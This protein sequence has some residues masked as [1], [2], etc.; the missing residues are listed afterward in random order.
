MRREVFG[1]VVSV[2]RFADADQAIA[3]ANDSDYGLASSV[4]T[5]DVS[6]AMRVA[7]ALHY[8]CTW[9]NT[10]FMLADEMPHAARRHEAVGLRQGY[11]NLRARRLHRRAPRHGRALRRR[12]C[13]GIDP[14]VTG[15]V[16]QGIRVMPYR[17]APHHDVPPCPAPEPDAIEVSMMTGPAP[18]PAPAEPRPNGW[19]AVNIYLLTGAAFVVVVAGISA[20]ARIVV[21]FLLAL[22]VA[23]ICAPLYQGMRRRGLPSALAMLMVVL[24]MLAAMLLLV[25]LIER[26]VGVLSGNLPNYLA[27]FFAQTDKL[28]AW[29]GSHG[30]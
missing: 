15:K 22:F 20:A 29:L 7:A 23:V 13:S 28:W 21:P 25:G 8:G 6:K 10:H 3:W 30:L 18:A 11:V 5:T 19:R 24:L 27:A 1:P 4:W 2:T 16:W 12:T 26:A 17:G 9:I 14:L